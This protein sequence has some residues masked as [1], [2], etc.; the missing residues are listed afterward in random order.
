MASLFLARGFQCAPDRDRFRLHLSPGT[1]TVRSSLYCVSFAWRTDHYDWRSFL[2]AALS[3]ALQ[4]Y[5]STLLYFYTERFDGSQQS[6]ATSYGYFQQLYCSAGLVAESVSVIRAQLETSLRRKTK[7]Q[8]ACSLMLDFETVVLLPSTRIR[9]LLGGGSVT[10]LFLGHAN[11]AAGDFHS[12]TP[13]LGFL[14]YFSVC[15]SGF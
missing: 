6:S 2:K 9:H 4:Q 13:L 11:T 14:T 5:R 1:P 8:R 3:V 12:H 10:P 15:F 7:A